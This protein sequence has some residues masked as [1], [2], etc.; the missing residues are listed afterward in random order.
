MNREEVIAAANSYE[1][2]TYKRVDI[3]AARGE[4]SWLWDL[5]GRKYL[6]LYG[7]HAV[8][9][10]GHSPARLADAIA[11]QARDLI[12]YS[13]VV[14]CPARARAAKK[15]AELSPF[16]EAQVFFCNSGAE[17]NETALKIARKATG[18]V[19]VMVY[20]QGFHGRTLGALAASTVAPR[21]AQADPVIPAESA[22]HFAEWGELP[23]ERF[24]AVLVE[25]IQSMGGVRTIDFAEQLRARCRETG[26]L[27]IFDEVQTA[28][29][30]T[31]A[32]FFADAVPD[33]I[34][35][36]KG[37]AGGFPA[38][39]VIADK[40]VAMTVSHGDQGTTF[41]GGPLA[42]VAIETTLSMLEE[43]DAPARAR[44]I[45]AQV[46]DRFPDALGRG[47]LLGI[48]G[49]AAPLREKGVLVGGCPGD[50]R[51]IRLMPP[52]NI[53]EEELA[54]GLDAIASL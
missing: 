44:A 54:L 32:W 45:E 4:G 14:H 39:V 17:A 34:T 41:G 22:Y 9:L 49:A 23:D 35:T 5:D 18:R 52:L 38:G 3:V 13:N 20:K 40:P 6:D 43:I 33:L 2:P 7:G 42:A 8:T 16:E 26:A 50:P 29:A 12:F 15:L 1:L 11:N 31:G 47:A 10:L 48:E 25:P 21:E 19:P 30:R 28:P 24:A 46:R 37:V 51:L 27:L 36:A 53:T